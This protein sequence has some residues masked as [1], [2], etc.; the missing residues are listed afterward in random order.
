[1]FQGVTKLLLTRIPFFREV[2]VGS[3]SCDHCGYTDSEINSAGRIQDKGV[4]I[5]LQVSE[6]AVSLQNAFFIFQS[7]RFGSL[8]FEIYHLVIVYK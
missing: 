8:S 1:M 5:A 2:I 7:N 6:N 3:F 4:R